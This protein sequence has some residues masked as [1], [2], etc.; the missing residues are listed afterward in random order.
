MSIKKLVALTKGNPLNSKGVDIADSVNGLIENKYPLHYSSVSATLRISGATN[1]R[2]V[3]VMVPVE[4]SSVRIGIPQ[5]GGSGNATGVTA[6]VSATDDIGDLSYTNTAACKKF[7]TPMLEGVEY[8]SLSDEGWKSVSWDGNASVDILDAGVG[9][10]ATAWS[11][12]IDV[13]SRAL[14]VDLDGTFDG[15]FPLMVRVFTTSGISNVNRLAGVTLPEY[16]SDVGARVILNS[17]RSG[18]SVSSPSAWNQSN[19]LAATDDFTPVIIEAYTAEKNISVL[20]IG[21]SRLATPPTTES[22][23][24]YKTLQWRIERDAVAAGIKFNY[25]ASSW[26]G[27][28]TTEYFNI[29]TQML[30]SGKINPTASIYLI[31]SINNGSPTDAEMASVK[32]KCLRHIK[33]CVDLGITPMLM[34]SFPEGTGFTVDEMANLVEL[35]AFAANTGLPM[36]SPLA[37]YGDNSGGWANPSDHEDSSHM[38]PLGYDD[39]S[40]RWL[41][42]IQRSL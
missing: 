18:D 17:V 19:S 29:A 16:F 33:Q 3:V 34:T 31:Y 1:T 10:T 13:Q 23:T 24:D 38:T 28:N 6:I 26:G 21:D 41:A 37:I 35:D 12:V 5:L 7:I 2:L 15:Y 9:H 20:T 22:A 32:A 39:L 14:E 25:I 27:R 36:L 40:S 4:F 11:D 30:S 8:N 42:V